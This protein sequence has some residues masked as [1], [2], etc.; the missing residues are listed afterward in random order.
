MTNPNADRP[1]LYLL[2]VPLSDVAPE[3]VMP[4]ANIE[5]AR[6]VKHFIVE[7]IRSPGTK[8]HFSCSRI[9]METKVINMA[10]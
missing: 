8:N 5:V 7:N 10:F 6:R 3:V 2:P 9:H 4:V 1:T